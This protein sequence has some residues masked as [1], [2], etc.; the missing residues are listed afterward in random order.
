MPSFKLYILSVM[1]GKRKTIDAFIVGAVLAAFSFIYLIILKCVYIL[2]RT[3]ILRQNEVPAKVISV[4]NIT[5]GGTGKTPFV[6]M[7]AS[8]SR[9]MGRKVAV[10]IRGYGDDESHL[11][12]ERLGGIRVIAGADRSRNAQAAISEYGCDCI[13]LDDGFQHHRLKRDLDIVLIDATDPFGNMRLFPRGILREPLFRMKD[14]DI[15]VLNK[16]DMDPVNKPSI[17]D[18]LKDVKGDVK[19]AESFYRAINFKNVLSDEVVPLSYIK[20][21]TVAL[22]AGIANPEYFEWMIK[23]LGA[24]IRERFYYVDHHLY[25]KEDV[26][27]IVKRCRVADINIVITTEKDIAR[28]SS[29]RGLAG[30]EG[31]TLLALKVDLVISKNEEAIVAGLHSLFSS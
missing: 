25:S 6:I 28:K 4:G 31:I 3:K 12:E 11:L 23:N 2:Y 10:L 17:Y 26:D 16:S 15:I 20:G 14:A 18:R 7:L 9:A 29:P 30:R 1:N 8:M 21:K 22:V 13:I 19:V 5:L 24:D 27:G